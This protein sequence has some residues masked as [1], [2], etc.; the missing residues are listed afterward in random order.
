MKGEHAMMNSIDRLTDLSRTL[1]NSRQKLHALTGEVER[2]NDNTRQSTQQVQSQI[3][4]AIDEISRTQDEISKVTREVA[5]AISQHG[6]QPSYQQQAFGGQG[7]QGQGQ[8]GADPRQLVN[9]ITQQVV[10]QLQ[11]RGAFGFSAPN[12]SGQRPVGQG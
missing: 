9:E 10:Q 11:Q 1:D 2:I 5:Q 6:Y 3:R 4:S 8:Q 12:A 7:W